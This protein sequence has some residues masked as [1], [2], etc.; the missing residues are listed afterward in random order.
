VRDRSRLARSGSREQTH[1][2]EQ[3]LGRDTLLLIEA[4]EQRL[5][6]QL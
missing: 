4:R 3:G 5:G 1:G 6:R 2:P